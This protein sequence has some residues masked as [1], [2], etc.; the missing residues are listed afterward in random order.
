M[1]KSSQSSASADRAPSETKTISPWQPLRETAFALLWG[2]MLISNIGTWMHDVAAGWLMT[3]LDPSPFMVAMVQA[4]TTL[5]VFFLALP[6]GALAD[7]IDKRR[8]L[9]GVTLFMAVTASSLGLFVQTGAITPYLLIIYTLLIG[10]GTAF[11][12]PTWHSVVPRLVPK[13]QLPQA[14]ALNS[15]GFNIA[16]AIGP[17][18]GGLL[19]AVIGIAFPFYL[20]ALSFIAVIVAVFLWRPND[21]KTSALPSERLFGAIRQGLRYTRA[22]PPMRATVFR[23]IAFFLFAGS[24]WALLPLIARAQLQGGPQLYGGL[25]A[26]IGFGAVIGASVLPRLKSRLGIDRLVVAGS[27]STAAMMAMFA[28]TTNP[29]VAIFVAMFAGA[30]WITVLSTLNVA[31]QTALP[32]WV[33]ARG[34]SVFLMTLFGSLAIGSA[35][36]GQVANFIGIS[37][38]L[39]I[40]AAG[41]VIGMAATWRWKLA[42]GADLDFTPSSWAE[43]AMAGPIEDERGPVMVT[44]EYLIDPKSSREFLS[45]LDEIAPSRK[46]DGAFAWGVFEDVAQPGR[47]MEYFMTE[48][49]LEHLRQHE[50]VTKADEAMTKKLRAFHIGKKKPVIRHFVSPEH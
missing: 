45:V 41:V 29:L 47:Y 11:L 48:S 21:Q 37:A 12:S 13:S 24:Y 43:P 46:R 16:R 40:S 28:V 33:R 31:A 26:A 4:A 1:P 15:V 50:R 22:S 20:N 27:L 2:A 5:P 39:M 6:A 10:T 44:V 32:E 19:I 3:S 35:A 30:S 8:L 17:A 9:I 7:I 36:W 34:L 42:P 14:V 25:L 38:T 23:S 18:I 49:W